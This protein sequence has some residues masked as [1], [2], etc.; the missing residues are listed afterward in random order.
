MKPT[1]EFKLLLQARNTCMWI[2]TVEERRAENAIAAVAASEG[3][4]VRFWDCA[5]GAKDVEGAAIDLGGSIGAASV[6]AKIADRESRM[7]REVW[8]LRDLHKWLGNPQVERMLKTIARDLQDEADPTKWAS[9]VVLAPSPEVPET[10]RNSAVTLDWPLPTRPELEAILG[11]ALAASKAKIKGNRS[12]AVDAMAGLSADDAASAIARSLAEVGQ[13][14]PAIIA[15]EKKRIINRMPGLTWYQPD[16]R[17]LDGVGGLEF[18]KEDLEESWAAFSPEA[19][20]FGVPTPRGVLVVGISGCGKSLVAKAVATTWNLPLIRMDMGALRNSLVGSSEAR[21]RNA[22][23][24]L[25]S[26]GRCV[27]LLDEIEKALGATGGTLDGG[28]GTDAL[29]EILTWLQDREGEVYLIATAN[30][31]Q[32]LPPEFTR[33]ERFDE[34]Y[35][36]DLP[37]FKGRQEVL[38]SALRHPAVNRNPADFDLAAVARATAN[39]SGAEVASLVSSALRTVF[40]AGGR[41]LT[42]AD[43]LEKAKQ[44]VPLSTSAAE[45]ITRLREWAETRARA[46]SIPEEKPKKSSTAAGGGRFGGIVGGGLVLDPAEVEAD[47]R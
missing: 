13:V 27:V 4:A 12:S 6:L 37:T 2:V 38:A 11:E 31:V 5:T 45:T 20:K 28:V 44:V 23:K 29:G 8:V 26:I 16:P 40:K 24:L 18:L 25:A 41:D 22:L 7:G 15:G 33:K 42:T 36:V 21:L 3:Y 39:Y 34:I 47:A 10:L 43:L 32:A 35:F 17:G 9:V 30:E 19:R 46:A 14:D 1:E